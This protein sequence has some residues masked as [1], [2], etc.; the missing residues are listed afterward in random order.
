LKGAGILPGK[1]DPGIFNHEKVLF[2]LLCGWILL[3]S[4]TLLQNVG[5]PVLIFRLLAD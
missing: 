4:Q 1:I 5:D 3:P 2:S